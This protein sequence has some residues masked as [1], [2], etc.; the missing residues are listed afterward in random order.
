MEI[1][2][3]NKEFSL[4]KIMVNV[5]PTNED[6]FMTLPYQTTIFELKNY[7]QSNHER[8]P[9]AK[10]QTIIFEGKVLSDNEILGQILEKT[11]KISEVNIFIVNC[12][13]FGDNEPKNKDNVEHVF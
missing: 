13:E 12:T 5:L 2:T 8:K 1:K 4:V 10:H 6:L 11:K 3:E 9:I 7:I